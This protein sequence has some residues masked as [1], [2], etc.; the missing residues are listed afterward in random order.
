MITVRASKSTR[1]GPARWLLVGLALAGCRGAPADRAAGPGTTPDG[2][3]RSPRIVNIINFVRQ[4]EPRIERITEEVLFDTVVEQ[5]E[6]MDRH[7]LTGTFLVQ[8][9]ALVDARYQELFRRLDPERYEI[10]AWWEIPQPLVERSGLTWRGRY[11]WDWHADVG[12]STGYTPEEREQL[13]D[14][15]MADFQSVFGR[16]PRSVGSWFIDAHTLRYMQERYG[17]VASCNCKDQVGTDGYTLWGGYWNQGYYPSRLNAYMP[18]QTVE[19]QIPVPV[20]RMLGSDPI[21]QYDV[22]LGKRAQRVISLEPIY[23]PGGAS[24][25]WCRWYF[26]A[27]VDG[28]AMAY[29][30][31]QVGQENS[32]TWDRMAQ[33]FELQLELVARLEREGRVSTRTLA[34]TGEWFRARYPLTPPTAVTVSSDYSPQDLETVW[35][36]S[37]FFRANLLWEGGTLRFR[38]IHLFDERVSSDYLTRKGTSTSCL[39]Y[40]LPFVDGFHWSSPE[41]VAGLRFETLDGST[42]LGGDPAV[43]DGN[44]GQL[45]VRW[46]VQGSTGEITLAFDERTVSISAEGIAEGGWCLAFSCDESAELPYRTVDRKE[47][48]CV[49]RGSAY[50]VRAVQGE[51]SAGSDSGWRLLPEENRVVLDLSVRSPRSPSQ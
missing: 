27:F 45:T 46:S 8:Y 11:P 15:Y 43:D 4:C 3:N 34:D 23:D 18:A 49:F 47:A 19:G 6:C 2:D 42:L 29:G 44:D 33:G 38:D 35:F 5:I 16:Y 30:Y 7:Q 28:P 20:F 40:T 50:T 41:S 22:G 25:E 31:V 32:F 36:N 39:F 24:P 21:H 1:T 9:D 37:R 13:V 17:I 48:T 12:F 14:T 51:F 10:G 26:D